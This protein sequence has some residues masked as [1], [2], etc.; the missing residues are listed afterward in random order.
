[1]RDRKPL[2]GVCNGFQVLVKA[3]LLPGPPA[4]ATGVEAEFRQRDVTLT[5]NMPGRFVD[6][7]VRLRSVS[8]KCIW[9]PPEQTLRLPIAHGEGRL[10]CGDAGVLDALAQRDQVALVY[11]DEKGAVARKFPD[12]PNGSAGAV[13]GLCDATGC[14]LGLMPHPERFV[15]SISDPLRTGAPRHEGHDGAAGDGM[16]FFRRAVEYVRTSA[17]IA[18]TAAS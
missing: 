1:M 12:N 14:V 18:L 17:A 16:I 13:A 9:L 15:E 2:L 10:M 5:F 6:T 11:A 8:K 4:D 7:W 3:G